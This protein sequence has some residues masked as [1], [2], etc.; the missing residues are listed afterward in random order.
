MA[1]ISEIANGNR[2]EFEMFFREHYAFLCHFASRYIVNNAEC[3]DIV[4]ESLLKYWENRKNF[5]SYTKVR[6]YIYTVIRNSCIDNIRKNNRNRR[7]SLSELNEKSYFEDNLIENES[8]N[9]FY[10][11]LNKLPDRCKEL[12][13]LALK[14][15]KNSEIAEEMGITEGTVHSIKKRAYKKLRDLLKDKYYLLFLFNFIR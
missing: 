14:G 3:E 2:K 1:S 8:Y 4:Q 15:F 9:L 6:S 7:K 13:E 12:I 5:N 10:T 11:A